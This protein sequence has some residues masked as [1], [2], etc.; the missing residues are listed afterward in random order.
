MSKSNSVKAMEQLVQAVKFF[1]WTVAVPK[2]GSDSVVG[3]VIGRE[4]YV[5]SI[6]ESLQKTKW[7]YKKQSS[8]KA[9]KAGG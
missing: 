7:K 6:M 1:G 2:T 5:E 9:K 8:T 3:M 4:D